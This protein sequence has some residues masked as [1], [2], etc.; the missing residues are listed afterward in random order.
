MGKKAFGDAIGIRVEG[1]YVGRMDCEDISP[2]Q[3]ARITDA[4]ITAVEKEGCGFAGIWTH[5]YRVP[6]E[7]DDEGDTDSTD[8]GVEVV[9]PQGVT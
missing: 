8:P 4:I 7:P 5:P 1:I 9:G 6:D 3:C 2:E